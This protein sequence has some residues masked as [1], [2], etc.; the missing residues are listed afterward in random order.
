MYNGGWLRGVKEDDKEVRVY[1]QFG[2]Y[3]VI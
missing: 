2:I 1:C 3:M